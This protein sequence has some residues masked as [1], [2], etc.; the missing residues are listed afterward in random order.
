MGGESGPGAT[1]P[2]GK[3]LPREGSLPTPHSP[4]VPTSQLRCVPA[5]SRVRAPCLGPRGSAAAPR[6]RTPRRV[7]R[8]PAE[9]RLRALGAPTA[10]QRSHVRLSREA[11][12]LL[13]R[14]PPRSGAEREPLSGQAARRPLLDP[15]DAS[16]RS[17]AA[18]LLAEGAVK[19][20]AAT[21]GLSRRLPFSAFLKR[22]SPRHEPPPG[23]EAAHARNRPQIRAWCLARRER[24][25][26][27]H[28]Q[29]SRGAA[30]PPLQPG[31][32]AALGR[33]V[34]QARQRPPRIPRAW[35]AAASCAAPG[36]AWKAN[37]LRERG[38]PRRE[39]GGRERTREG[40]A[41]N[42]DCELCVR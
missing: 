29:G 12:G 7:E 38:T 32:A 9:P 16:G 24:E 13:P 22:R 15:G 6:P 37:E 39:G 11:L 1:S 36:A 25:T 19:P 30:S 8:A 17:A 3:S 21:A 5:G 34:K 35:S 20:S 18:R 23:E 10:L 2:G 41:T 26:N 28:G 31:E 42:R 14:F 33:F 40:R 4:G 27:W